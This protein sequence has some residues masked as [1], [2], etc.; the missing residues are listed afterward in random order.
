MTRVARWGAACLLVAGLLAVGGS[1]L[2][3]RARAGRRPNVIVVSVD[4]ARAD[5]LGAWGYARPTS[6]TIDRLSREGVTFLHSYAQANESLFSHASLFASRF[7]GEIA[8][9]TYIH[10]AIPPALP[11]LAKRLKALGYRTGGFTGG[12][13]ISHAYG[14]GDGYDRYFD[15]VP[16]GSFAFSVPRALMWLEEQGAG[17]PFFMFLH[18]YDCHRPY[19]KPGVFN[20]LYTPDYTGNADRYLPTVQ[21]LDH[22]F[23]DRY[24]ADFTL[25][26]SQTLGGDHPSDAGSYVELERLATS[27]PGAGTP[28][29]PGDVPHIVA[30]FDSAITYS[31]TWLGLFLAGLDGLGYN[32]SNTLVVILADHGEDLMEHGMFNHRIGVEVGNLHVP[33]VFWGAGVDESLAGRRY[34][35]VTQNLDVAPTILSLLGA[36]PLPDGRGADLSPLLARG[37]PATGSTPE[38]PAYAEGILGMTTVLDRE[39]QVIVRGAVP[40]TAAMVERI[41]RA[42][43]TDATVTLYDLRRDPRETQ[44]VAGQSDRLPA[45]AERMRL[46]LDKERLVVRARAPKLAPP[47]DEKLRKELKD[48]GYW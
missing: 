41:E 46:L 28:L 18:G 1:M 5:H 36:A 7:P 12:A 43:P 20:H 24:Y 19:R 42:R 4:G 26:F 33:L 17:E 9:P 39:Y 21:M 30:H 8:L 40:G 25:R 31:D 35:Q 3:P 13:H 44:N 37:A 6:P 45:L 47:V 27:N 11:T 2:M 32:R 14:F 48:H 38:R 29:A 34:E 16:F 10:F 22:V 23:R 15:E